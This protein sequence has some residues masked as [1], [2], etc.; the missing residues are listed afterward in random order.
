[1]KRE[2]LAAMGL[3]K[4]NIDKIMADYGKG[5]QEAN[6]KAEKFKLDAE[7]AAGLQKEL[8]QYKDISAKAENLQKQLN[9]MKAKSAETVKEKQ[10]EVDESAKRIAELE[11]QINGVKLPINAGTMLF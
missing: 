8:S 9:E 10:T 4:E 11:Q 1:M 7:K 3:E 6:E 5:I 2:E